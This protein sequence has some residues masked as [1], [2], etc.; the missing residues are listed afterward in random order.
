MAPPCDELDGPL[1]DAIAPIPSKQAAWLKAQF[2]KA[3]RKLDMGKSCI[4]FRTLDDLPLEA[5]GEIVASTPV[6]AFLARY[7]A[8]RKR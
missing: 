1:T 7:Q 4:R 8:I 2:K 6:D 5:I 3:G